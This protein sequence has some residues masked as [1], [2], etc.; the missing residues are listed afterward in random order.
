M[1]TMLEVRAE[2]KARKAAAKA[3]FQMP[4]KVG[5][6]LHHSWGYEQTNCDFYQ[7]VHVG[8]RS[9]ALMKIDSAT[10][11]GSNSGGMCDMRMPVKD[12]FIVTGYHALSKGNDKINPDDPTIAKLVSCLMEP[13]GT[14]R[15]YVSTPYG[16]CSLWDGLPKS[17][18]WYG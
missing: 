8:A 12:S 9:V 11:P 3:Q 15:Y 13:S 16:W 2:R 14:V 18:S 4:Y 10:V 6:I 17:C 1:T 7:V 5:D